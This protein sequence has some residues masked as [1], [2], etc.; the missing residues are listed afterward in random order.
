MKYSNYNQNE[1]LLGKRFSFFNKEKKHSSKS[2]EEFYPYFKNPL[3]KKRFT[4][5]AKFQAHKLKKFLGILGFILVIAWGGFIIKFFIYDSTYFDVK[6]ILVYGTKQFVNAEDLEILI[7]SNLQN[8]NILYIDER[9][10]ENDIIKNFLGAK[11]ITIKKSLPDKLVVN[12]TERVPL[13]LLYQNEGSQLYLIDDDG[14]VLGKVAPQYMDLPRIQ[15][16]QDIEIGKTVAPEIVP[17][18]RQIIKESDANN[19][20]ISS[21]SF[22]PKYT[23]IYIADSTQALLSNEKDFGLSIKL[24]SSML[25]KLSLEGK[26][27]N[28]IDLRYDKVIVK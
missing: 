25:K 5:T 28:Q 16:V 17:T 7:D 8:R 13:A 24:L 3:E 1:S 12:V 20:K 6:D 22:T 19:L 21:M 10:I 11:K 18:T 23:R 9:K 2:S 14:Y 4:K 26:N 15:Y 27:V